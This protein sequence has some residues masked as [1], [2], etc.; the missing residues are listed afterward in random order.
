[1]DYNETDYVN[2]HVDYKYRYNGGPYLQLLFKLPGDNGMA[3]RLE[4]GDGSII[5]NDTNVHVIRI[6]ISDIKRNTSELN[7]R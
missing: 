4:K 5:L 2:A 6:E 7:F 3:Y 1:M